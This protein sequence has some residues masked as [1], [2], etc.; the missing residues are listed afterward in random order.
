[1]IK[2]EVSE[3]RVFTKKTTADGR[4]SGLPPNRKVMIIVSENKNISKR[5]KK[6]KK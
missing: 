3:D 1:M 4:V 5:K 2:I 6:R